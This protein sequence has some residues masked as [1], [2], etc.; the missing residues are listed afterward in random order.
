MLTSYGK[1]Y[2]EVFG[3]NDLRWRQLWDDCDIE[4]DGDLKAQQ[5]IRFCIYQLLQAYRSG[6]VSSVTAKGLTGEG[7]GLL[8]FWDS[9]IYLMPFYL[10]TMPEL[11][12]EILMFR[13]RILDQARELFEQYSQ[14]FPQNRIARMYLGEPIDPVKTYTATRAAPAWAQ[15]QREGLERLL[16]VSPQEEGTAAALDELTRLSPTEP[17]PVAVEVRRRR[18][19]PI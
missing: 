7:Y 11:A 6:L 5:G 3:S 8:C 1:E 9:E 18:G 10:Y 12:R 17:E 14:R 13:Y 19:P 15:Y 2:A 4:I 16:G